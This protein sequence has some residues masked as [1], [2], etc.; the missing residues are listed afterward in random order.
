M[1][2][3]TG[4]IAG[5][6]AVYS[7]AFQKFGAL[8]IT[9]LEELIDVSRAF[10]VQSL[11]KGN[12]IGVLTAS[13]GACSVIADLCSEKGLLVPEL[14]ES[15]EKIR[16]LIPPFGSA[17]NPVDVTA[18][19]IAKPEMFK[20]VLQT[21]ADDPDIDGVIVMLTT[22]ADPGAAVIAEAIIDVQ[23]GQNKTDCGWTTWSRSDRT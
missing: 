18:E 14:T 8:R 13:G 22:N 23:R 20:R 16:E 11:P 3:H 15:S 10:T 9:N 4:S 19:V 5:D 1:Q 21:L 7:A 6:D 12:R 2:S 17:Q